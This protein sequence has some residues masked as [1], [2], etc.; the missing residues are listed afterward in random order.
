MKLQMSASNDAE[1]LC[2]KQFVRTRVEAISPAEF[3]MLR[4]VSEGDES[5]LKIEMPKEYKSIQGPMDI[6]VVA[7]LR[8]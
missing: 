4:L 6:R 8:V 2:K 7:V 1:M 3:G 5:S